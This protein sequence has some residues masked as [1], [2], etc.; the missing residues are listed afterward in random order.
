MVADVNPADLDP[1]TRSVKYYG[2][3]MGIY[4]Y[5]GFYGSSHELGPWLGSFSSP[6]PRMKISQWMKLPYP[7]ELPGVMLPTIRGMSHQV[8]FGKTCCFIEKPWEDHL[9]HHNDQKLS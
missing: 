9:S 2:N 3:T 1:K 6:R 4:I 7:T 8:T 5:L